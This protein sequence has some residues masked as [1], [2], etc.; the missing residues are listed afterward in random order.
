MI[1]VVVVALVGAAA[2]Y[3]IVF[4]VTRERTVWRTTFT[5]CTVGV[6]IA[7]VLTYYGDRMDQALQV[8]NLSKLL[9]HLVLVVTAAATM[10]YVATLKSPDYSGRAVVV[11]VV[12]AT[13]VAALQVASWLAAP[14][15]TQPLPSFTGISQNLSVTVF[16]GSFVAMLLTS[17]LTTAHFCVARA[18]S[19]HDLTRTIS[20]S[21]TGGAC[22][23]GALVF[24]LY[25]VVVVVSYSN[26]ARGTEIM[27][28]SDALLPLV[29]IVLALGT[30]ALLL[31]PGILQ[32]T[33]AYR[34]W[35]SLRPLW[36][37]MISRHPQV[38]LDTTLSG[39]P[40]RR[41]QNRVQR[42][43]VESYDALRL[44]RVPLTSEAGVEELSQALL[45][46]GRTGSCTATEV[47][48]LAS[49]PVDGAEKI[50]ELAKAYS[51]N[52]R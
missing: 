25:A 42:A 35:R 52:R 23:A 47:L 22:I 20:L 46:P 39:T 27:A 44:T 7:A 19:R 26:P 9:L 45:Q 32:F 11:P 2:I 50:V 31:A 49:T 28:F 21:L 41:L 36:Q 40:L 1:E 6:A 38:H 3:R 29:L 30:L 8:W 16:N 18:V 24:T 15:H 33:A 51:R 34:T 5:I 10:V 4:S 17:T 14:V 37:D 48:G 43:V 12:A 13:G